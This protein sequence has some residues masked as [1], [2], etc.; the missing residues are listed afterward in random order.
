MENS[1]HS[2]PRIP[3]PTRKLS[4]SLLL[5]ETDDGSFTFFD[6]ISGES[7]HSE[8]GAKTESAHVFLNNSGTEERLR[9]KT[10][11]RILEVGFGTGLNFWVTAT[12]A[13]RN[14]APLQYLAFD[15][16]WYGQYFSELKFPKDESNGELFDAY[17][18]WIQS[19]LSDR[20]SQSW[21]FSDASEI[22]L[23]VLIGDGRLLLRGL[24][25]NKPGWFHVV[26][27]D[28]FSPQACPDLWESEV[29]E[30]LFELLQPGGVLA[31]YCVKSEI[32]KRLKAI[33]FDVQKR[34][35]PTNG[36]REVLTAFKPTS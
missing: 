4:D 26:Y 21:C 35:V 7:F 23:N 14:S 5:V 36:K 9:Q 3:R 10:E 16:C 8:A 15:N 17:G 33:G 2:R 32:Q 31:T 1:P 12:S 28:A 27:H 13:R 24:T 20:T 19:T 22:K 11:T 18:N 6:T 30:D 34:K 29:F 25:V